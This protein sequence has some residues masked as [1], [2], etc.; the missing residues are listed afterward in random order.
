MNDV[1]LFVIF[2][3]TASHNEVVESRV[4]DDLHRP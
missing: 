3:V 1:V 4:T 2:L